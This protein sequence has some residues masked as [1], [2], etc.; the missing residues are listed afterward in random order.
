MLWRN[1]AMLL[2]VSVIG[3]MANAGN[4]SAG[5]GSAAPFRLTVKGQPLEAAVRIT[6]D[7]PFILHDGSMVGRDRLVSSK[8]QSA[9]SGRSRGRRMVMM[10]I[11]GAVGAGVGGY[12]GW[13]ACDRRGGRCNYAVWGGLAGVGVGAGIGALFGS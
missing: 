1:I 2:A 13:E 10:L 3:P 12:L 8:G 6:P 9:I 4:A 11:G 7:A 5:E